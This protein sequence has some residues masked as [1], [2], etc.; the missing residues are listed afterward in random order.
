KDGGTSAP[1]TGTATVAP[2][3]AADAGGPYTVAEGG[4]LALDA[5]GSTAGPTATYAWDL[6]GDGQ[7]DDATG[8]TPT[9]THAD[10]EA[11]GRGDGPSTHTISVQ[12]TEGPS[13]DTD[14]ATV[15][16]TNVAPTAAVVGAVGE[17]VAGGPA[18]VT[19]SASD[20]SAADTAA[21]FTYAIDWG[22]GS[23]VQP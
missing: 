5:S 23:P 20:P 10:L 8:A 4:S 16:V 9:V 1:A 21:G 18:T 11:A 3:V 15:T 7:F 12:V 6:D 19:F 22:D 17:I 13:V 14:T 2:F